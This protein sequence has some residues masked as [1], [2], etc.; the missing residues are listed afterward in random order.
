MIT[1]ISGSKNSQ[2]P[3]TESR[4]K[5][6]RGWRTGGQGGGKHLGFH[7]D[8]ASIAGNEKSSGGGWRS[9]LHNRRL[10]DAATCALKDS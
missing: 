8:K 6:A 3:E 4:M 9:R 10:L 2:K 5:V 1:L 7:G